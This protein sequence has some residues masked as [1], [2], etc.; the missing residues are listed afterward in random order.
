MNIRKSAAT[1]TPDEISAFLEAIIKLKARQAP[2][3]QAKISVYDQF[4]ALHGAVM[5]VTVNGLA[6]PIN[7]A[8]GNIG[9]LAWHRQYLHDF[10]QALQ[11]EVSEVTLPYWDWSDDIGATNQL[12]TP[13]FLS[14]TI[15]GNPTPVSNGVLQA[16]IP[17]NKKPTWWPNNIQGFSINRH[18]QEGLGSTLNRGSTDPNWPPSPAEMQQLTQLNFSLRGRNPLWAFWLV[19]EQGNPA[20]SM[21]THN[22]GHRFV[23]GHMAGAFSPNDPIFWLHHANVDR[24]WAQWQAF[25]LRNQAGSQPSDFWPAPNETSPLDGRLAPQGHKLNDEMWPWVGSHQAQYRSSSISQAL[26]NRL[27]N[28]SNAPVITVADV[29]DSEAMA[30]RYQ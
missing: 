11:N 16:R 5:S 22:A 23:G 19:L 2:N 24:V 25:Q 17:A 13:E 4:V 9:F 26:L 29:L 21:N 14:S 27:A 3:T 30:V 8:H 12:F 15:W 7:F 6:N 20:V 18:L 28:F 10:E 1:L